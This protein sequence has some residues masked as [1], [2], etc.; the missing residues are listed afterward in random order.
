VLAKDN[1]FLQLFRGEL[2]DN[3]LKET[4]APKTDH[5]NCQVTCPKLFISFLN[6]FLVADVGKKD[7][8][9]YT[10]RK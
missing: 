8:I 2:F 10:A 1:I 6:P 9:I 4:M 3:A 7:I 5:C